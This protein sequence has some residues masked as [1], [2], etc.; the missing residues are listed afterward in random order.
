M[1][2]YNTTTLS[3]D[4]YWRNPITPHTQNKIVERREY[5][6]GKLKYVDNSGRVVN[7]NE[8]NE[9]LLIELEKDY[10]KMINKKRNMINNEEE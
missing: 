2:K 3:G 1:E 5:L 4:V 6:D 9:Y 8:L 10:F 7:I